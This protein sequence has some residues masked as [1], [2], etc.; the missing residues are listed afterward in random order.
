MIFQSFGYDNNNHVF[1]GHSNITGALQQ[2]GTYFYRVE[3]IVNGERKN[4]RGFFV[5]KYQ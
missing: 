2:A 3:F 5:L 1:G 4:K